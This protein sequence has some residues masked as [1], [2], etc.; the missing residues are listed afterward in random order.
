MAD[1]RQQL[2]RD[3][4]RGDK[5]LQVSGRPFC[6]GHGVGASPFLVL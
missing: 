4:M 1:L 2:G 5:S 3:P 6:Y